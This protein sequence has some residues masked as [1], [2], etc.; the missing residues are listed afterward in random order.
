VGNAPGALAGYTVG[1][2]ADRRSDEQITLLERR[3]ARVLHG[4][5]IRTLPLHEDD[6]WFA[7]TRQLIARP[8]EL[9][10]LTTAIGVRSWLAAAESRGVGDALLA[11]LGAGA[12]LTRG[13]KATGAAVTIGL[14]V[15]WTS[16]RARSSEILDHVVATAAPGSRIAIQLDGGTNGYV[17]D[18]LAA[19]GF[20]VVPIRIYGWTLPDDVAPAAR[21][22]AAV[23]DGALD[24]VTFTAGPALRNFLALAEREGRIDAVRD[25]FAANAVDLVLIG[26]ACADAAAAAGLD[27]AVVPATARLGA[28][29]QAYVAAVA[30]RSC[31]LQLAGITVE[32]QGRL[33]SIDGH[34]QVHLSDRERD[35]LEALARRPGAVVSKATLVRE[36][37]SNQGDE[38]IAE[39]TVARLRQRLGHAGAGI[40]TVVRRGY[41]LCA[42]AS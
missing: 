36:V 20:D 14:D 19:A 37:W 9:V 2:T 40:E 4:P 10:V 13:P 12:V 26:P 38:H 6:E 32:L 27:G 17:A 30:D 24:A 15:S 28:M 35:V 11:A 18:E 42:E 33:V 21:L 25:A 3:G 23:G 5:T 29:V 39:V 1:V 8:P 16:G 22:I 31:R 7:A 34:G 41:R